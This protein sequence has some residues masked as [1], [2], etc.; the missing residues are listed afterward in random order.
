MIQTPPDTSRYMP[1]RTP[2]PMTPQDF[3]VSP[4]Q[5][6]A[7]LRTT[8]LETLWRLGAFAPAV[9]VTLYLIR[10]IADLL[11]SGGVS[12]MEAAVIVLVG[13]TFVW[14][15]FSVS[16]ATLG[17]IRRVV[18]PA[19]IQRSKETGQAMSVALL[20]PVYNETT[21]EVFGNAQA[22]LKDLARRSGAD[23]YTLFILSDTRD[24]AIAAQEE[25]AYHALRA[26]APKGT[27][28]FYRRRASNI[29]KKVGNLS[30]WISNW[31]AAYEAMVILD[32]DSLMSGAAIRHLVRE[33]ANDP[34]AGLIQSF[35]AVIGA[36]TL[37]G[38]M[39]Q[40]SN[41]VYGWLLA[42]GVA[43]WSLR[44][45]NYWGHNAIIRT[46]AFA[47]SAQLPYLRG[48]RGRK[49][50]ILSHD[51]VE[52]GLLRRAGWAVR[53]LPRGGGSFEE[54]P[55]TLIDY[56]L[57]DRRWCQGNLQHLRL[58][59]ARGFH[60]VS[61]FHLLQ[62][63]VA[64][65]LSPAWLALIVIWSLLDSMPVEKVTY[66]S[67]PNPLYPIW[68]G[69][70]EMSGLLYLAFIYTMLLIPKLAGTLALILR[71]RSRQ[72]N[73][74]AL[75]LIAAALFEITLSIFYAPILMVQHTIAVVLA[76]LGRSSNWTPQLRGAS[77]YGW[78][79]CLRFHSVET[80]LGIVLATAIYSGVAS[81]WLLPIAISLLLSTPLSKLSALRVSH[82]RIPVLRLDSRLTLSEPRIVTSARAERET[83]RRH[84]ETH[85]A[86]TPVAAE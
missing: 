10:G 2:L 16:T 53:F 18:H 74:G 17:L 44:E 64:F 86:P 55:Q 30:D 57:R 51:F 13:I 4:A 81:V 80:L 38:R 5:Q 32:A 58:L 56:V 69:S 34:S 66:F 47:Q 39:Q 65:L 11:G 24:D 54:A 83:I 15:S 73:G 42:E 25:R 52:A 62:G 75:A 36:E 33:L 85:S 84:L 12:T 50:L 26:S 49:D 14:V 37:F 68:P 22:M 1:A 3:R 31:G 60:P 7:P 61:R 23:R 76:L 35:P 20:V 43:G 77:I 67:E 45:G 79:H 48:R 6:A 46:R 41:A 78:R 27:E 8:V 71:G 19:W 72:R 40:F 82:L 63:A 59:A 9:A 70:G 29:D 21:W 28:I